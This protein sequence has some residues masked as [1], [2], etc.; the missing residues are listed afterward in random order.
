MVRGLEEGTC[1][2]CL[3]SGEV[4]NERGLSRCPDCDGTG[5]IGDIFSRN[6]HRL[7]EIEQ[8]TTRLT[9]EAGEDTHWLIVELRRS[10]AALLKVMTAA[11]DGASDDELLRR[12]QF[13]ANE[14]LGVYA[15]RQPEQ[16]D[17]EGAA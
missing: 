10:R 7:R 17:S 12:I 2:T 5:K 6:E 3:G 15:A 8:K 9:G 11:Q 1:L 13:E 16:Q 14:V 4:S